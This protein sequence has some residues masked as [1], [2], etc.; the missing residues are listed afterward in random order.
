MSDRTKLILAVTLG[1]VGL[2]LGILGTVVAFNA[3]NAV[4]SNQE[5]ASV[6][7]AEFA[8]A[9]KRQ[10]QLE[11]SQV[12]GAEKLVDSLS[13][14]EKNQLGKIYSNAKATGRLR[15]RVNN[16]Q[17]QIDAL[18]STTRQLSGQVSNLQSQTQKNFNRLNDRIDRTNQRIDNR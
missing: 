4:R 14:S 15:R 9:Q 18:K 11:E 13:R 2:A 16:Q 5:I 6:V 3:R 10:D 7:E 12:S 8:E 1:S 17:G